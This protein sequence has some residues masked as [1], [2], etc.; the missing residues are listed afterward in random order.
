MLVKQIKDNVDFLANEIFERATKKGAWITEEGIEVFPYKSDDDRDLIIWRNFIRRTRPYEVKFTKVLKGL[1]KAQEREVISNIR[2]YPKRG[3]LN[4]HAKLAISQ[5]LPVLE[6]QN[7]LSQWLF[8]EMMWRRR[9]SNAGKPFIGGVLEDVGSAELTNLIVGIDFDISNPLVQDFIN[10]NADKF[11]FAT[12]QTTIDSLRKQLIAGVKLGESIPEL[13][14]RVNKVF[15]FAE[16]YRATRIS[17]TEILKSANMG[18][19]FAY[20]QSGVVKG[21]EWILAAGACDFCKYIA[22]EMNQRTLGKPWFKKG[23]RLE[24]PD[25]QVMTIDYGDI[26]NPPLHPSGK[27]TIVAVLKE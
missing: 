21:K 9:F 22:A 7:W 16:K 1:F 12:N 6:K 25:G 20:I 5:L 24:L 13:T 8:A 27:C 18:S 23:D 26:Q 15:G 10:K 17:R 19:E 4:N 11:S 3:R 14:K 2:K